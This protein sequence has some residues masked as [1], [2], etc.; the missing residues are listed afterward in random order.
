MTANNY[1]N[2]S[3][4]MPDRWIC[5][6]L[7][8][9]IEKGELGVKTGKGFYD[10]TGKDMNQVLAKRDRQLFEAFK[11]SKKLMEDPV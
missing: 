6:T 5:R 7:A 1:K 3:Y 4:T 10:Y 8:E 11:L 9:H 2:K